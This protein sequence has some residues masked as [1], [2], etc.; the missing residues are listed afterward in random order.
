MKLLNVLKNTKLPK[1]KLVLSLVT[2]LSA[3]TLSN[4][5]NGSN[6]KTCFSF[7]GNVTES[8]TGA[9]A[10]SNEVTYVSSKNGGKD[11]ACSFNGTASSYILLPLSDSLKPATITLSCLVKVVDASKTQF[12]VFSKNSNN[13]DFEGFALL[14]TNSQFKFIINR[15]DLNVFNNCISSSINSNK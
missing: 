15:P 10:F 12:V 11:S 8:V 4:A 2:M 1:S 5:Q 3:A 13:I 9:K 14:V 6:L 7:N